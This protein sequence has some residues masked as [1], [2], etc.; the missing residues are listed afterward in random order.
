ME[1]LEFHRV[2]RFQR[3]HL[4]GTLAVWILFDHESHGARYIIFADRSVRPEDR[5]PGS[6]GSM[7]GQER[8]DGRDASN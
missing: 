2:T 6:F 8:C 7:S 4:A 1:W 5:N 3:V